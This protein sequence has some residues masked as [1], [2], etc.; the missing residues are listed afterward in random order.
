[1]RESR[2]AI[3]R[4]PGD[5]VAAALRM[6]AYEDARAA[7]ASERAVR[8]VGRPWPGQRPPMRKARK[9]SRVAFPMGRRIAR[10]ARPIGA[11]T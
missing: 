3:R 8:L 6:Y 9:T 4:V 7:A 11:S 5:V 2:N 10:I 1:M